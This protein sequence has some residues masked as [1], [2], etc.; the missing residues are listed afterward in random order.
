MKSRCYTESNSDYK[1]YGG[2]GISI[3]DE[4]L[5]DFVSFYNWSMNNS[6]SDGLSIDRIDVNGNYEPS[7][8]RWATNKE[9][10]NNKRTN[11]FCT[12]NGETKT[13]KEWSEERGII[14]NT[15]RHRL[16]L[17]YTVE[18]ALDPDFSRKI[19]FKSDFNKEIHEK[20]KLH[21]IPYERVI[22]RI[23]DGW[24]IERALTEPI[25]PKKGKH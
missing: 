16:A 22:R 12:I 20:C 1:D 14:Y 9:Q 2:R 8:C 11:M 7:N 19:P 25:R 5:N 3:C 6:Y 18:E 15:V 21:N 17:G 13:L 10:A 4:W 24:D 23:K